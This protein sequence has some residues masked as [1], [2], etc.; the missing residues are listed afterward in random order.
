MAFYL[1]CTTALTEMFP[2]R[3]GISAE[4]GLM[5]RLLGARYVEQSPEIA[6]RSAAVPTRVGSQDLLPPHRVVQWP[7]PAIESPG[8]SRP[9]HSGSWPSASG[10]H[11][12]PPADLPAAARFYVPP[13]SSP[14]AH[15]P[16]RALLV[17]LRAL[18]TGRFL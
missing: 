5:R 14:F 16:S 1:L 17:H 8:S 3:E 13:L 4:P 6:G 11:V 10:R 2:I 15:R 18:E 12:A 7:S 9:A